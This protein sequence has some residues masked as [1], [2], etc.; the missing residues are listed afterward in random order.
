MNLPLRFPLFAKVEVFGASD[1]VLSAYMAQNSVRLVESGEH[2]PTSTLDTEV[3]SL[4]TWVYRL[5]YA[6]NYSSA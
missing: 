5:L 3:M 1:I 4:G 6:I 2:S